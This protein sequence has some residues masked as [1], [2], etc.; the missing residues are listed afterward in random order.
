MPEPC[1]F[2]TGRGRPLPLGVTPSIDGHNFA[3]L[4]RH[5]THATLVILP[6]YG[7]TQSQTDHS[8]K[9]P[10]IRSKTAPATTGTSASRGCPRSSATAGASMDRAGPARGSTQ[11]GFCSTR[12]GDGSLGRSRLGRHVRETIR[13]GRRG[14]ACYHRGRRYHWDDDAPPLN[15]LEDSIIYELH[16]RGFTCHPVQPRRQHPAPFAG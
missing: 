1:P 13:N 14:A 16:V 3:L 9:Y 4:C 2:A 15:P 5:G 8:P 12:R 6:G 10:S 7:Q 11:T